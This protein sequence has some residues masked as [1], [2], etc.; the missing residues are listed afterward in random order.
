MQMFGG[1]NGELLGGSMNDTL[2]DSVETS[3]QRIARVFCESLDADKQVGLAAVIDTD[4][5]HHY[6][7][8]WNDA[9]VAA[10]KIVNDA[11]FEG[12][13]DLRELVARIRGL[14]GES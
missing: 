11:R 6:Q 5:D 12:G 8:G 14:K 9:V 10:A 1:S 7:V 4:A 3:G 2:R 13:A